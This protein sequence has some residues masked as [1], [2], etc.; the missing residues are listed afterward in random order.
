MT[1]TGHTVRVGPPVPVTDW[2]TEGHLD[3]VYTRVGPRTVLARC[4]ATSPLR[5]LCPIDLDGCAYTTILNTS[6]GIV[7]GDVLCQRIEIG[8][9]AHALVTT[10]SATKVYRSTE[11][12][13]RS[14]TTID[15]GAGAVLEWLPDPVIPYAGARFDQSL[16]VRVHAGGTAIVTEA[17]VVGRVARG[18]RWAFSLLAN[19]LRIDVGGRPAVRDRYTLGPGDAGALEGWSHLAAWYA[20]SGR[21]IDWP[22][23]SDGLA[24]DLDALHPS[25]YGGVSTLARG[26]VVVRCVAAS[27]PDLDVAG[28]LVWSRLRRALLGSAPP[29]L[30][31]P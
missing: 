3:L 24:G 23:L 21:E 19:D 16:H 1:G 11:A 13:A 9:G 27:A 7:A 17:W 2:R 20:V 15:V 30:R 31:K 10:P 14:I 12:I 18:E 22:A 8:A 25:V 29:L 28:A 4:A 5:V 6:G 26:E